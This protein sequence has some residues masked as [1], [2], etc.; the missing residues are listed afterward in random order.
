MPRES[1]TYLSQQES[2]IRLE[3]YRDKVIAGMSDAEVSKATGV[4][5][6]TVK[7]WRLANRIVR[8]RGLAS[9][10][11][12]DVYAISQFGEMI[13]DVKQRAKDSPLD[14]LWE[15]PV[16]VT[17]QHLDYS[18]FVRLLDTGRRVMGLTNDELSSA[19]GVTP[20]SVEQGLVVCEKILRRSD[21]ICAHC[22]M[23]MIPERNRT[24]CSSICERL[25]H[26][27]R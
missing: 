5:P 19:L 24:Y 25:S 9:K 16:F 21:A 20:G 6:R 22:G 13:T 23:K 3:P 10:R 18:L 11:V 15:P 26:V 7:R 17:R 14:G 8:P 27:Q 1:R 12:E 4:S 2:S